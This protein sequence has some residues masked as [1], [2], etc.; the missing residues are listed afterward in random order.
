ML[1]TLIM[2]IL[3]IWAV[4]FLTSYTL[5]GLLHLLLLIALILLIY[6]IVTGRRVRV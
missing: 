6:R 4:G 3:L 2:L 1:W 5:G